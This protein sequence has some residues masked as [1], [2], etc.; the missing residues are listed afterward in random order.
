QRYRAP[1]ILCYLDGKT[2]DEAARRLRLPPGTLHARLQRG[3]D[4]LRERLTRRGLT[5]SGALF[6]AV[7][8]DSV[9][10]AA[11]APTLVI[12]TAKAALAIAANQP[13]TQGVISTS[14][15]ALTREA[16]KTMFVA[17][18]KLGTVVAFA[19]LVVAMTC[20]SWTSRGD[21]QEL[22]PTA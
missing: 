20:V 8:S 18:L 22:A 13:L 21:A 6:A 17:K 12:T 19:S 11:V 10:R 14:V 5:F 1:L 7:L 9:A 3:R 4:L 16:L 15:L 2:R